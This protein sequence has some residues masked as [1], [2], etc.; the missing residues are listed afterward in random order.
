MAIAQ[1][2]TFSDVGVSIAIGVSVLLL[3]AIT[4]VPSL[5]VLLG[6][7]LFWPGLKTRNNNVEKNESILSRIADATLKKKVPIVF[8]IGLLGLGSLYVAYI[9]PTGMDFQR[10]LPDFDSNRGITEIVENMGSDFISPTQ[11]V[12]VMSTPIVDNSGQLN[13]GSLNII[14][15]LTDKIRNSEGIASVTSSTQPFNA[16][17]DYG[18]VYSLS[19]PTR[20]QY[21]DGIFETIGRD[22]RTVL[23]NVGLTEP[24]FSSDAIESLLDLKSVINGLAIDQ[25]IE[26]HFGGTT[27]SIYESQSLLDSIFPRVVIILVA[28][29]YILLFI[30]LWSAFTPIRLIY[31]VLTSVVVSLALIYLTFF[32]IMDIP[33]ISFIALFVVVTML[34]VGIDYDIFLVTRIREEVLNGKSDNEAIKTAITKTAGTIMGLGLILSS[35]FGSL[36][37]TGMPILQEIGMAVS[38]AVLFDTFIVILFVVPA[39]MGLAQSL[40]WWPTKP[41]RS[42]K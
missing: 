12:V 21:L 41:K 29:I 18:T 30:Q 33:I 1:V 42:E 19:E 34:G 32:F 20:S 17:F 36:M 10:L 5:E 35:V 27:Q 7:K 22:N 24:P 3:V 14:E 25:D 39:L 38:G 40:N 16:E 13:Q 28:A 11:I 37:F 2:P 15:Q 6:D 23:I 4:L 31:T 9:T 8:A 26:I